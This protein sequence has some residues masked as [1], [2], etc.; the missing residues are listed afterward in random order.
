MT[1]PRTLSLPLITAGCLSTALYL[2]MS[3]VS[4]SYGAAGFAQAVVVYGGAGGLI[5]L[6]T[7]WLSRQL[8]LLDE[9]GDEQVYVSLALGLLGFGVLFRLLGVA[10][11]PVLEDDFYRYL[12]DGRLFVETGQPY[13]VAPS[14]YF[15]SDELSERFE[16]ILD[17]INYPGVAT[18]Y[19]PTLQLVF[20]LAYLIAP[21]EVW[22][23]QCLV[24]LADLVIL[25]ILFC[26]TGADT[27]GRLLGFGLYA[28]S[29]LLIKEFATTAH[30]D[31]L[32][33][34]LVFVA[35]SLWRRA[36]DLDRSSLWP[37]VLTGALLA[38]ASGVKP[39]ALIFAP[40]LIG[41]SVPRMLGFALGVVL[42]SLPFTGLDPSLVAAVWLPEGLR[43]MG[44]G[45]LFNAGLYE[46]FLWLGVE[47]LG[48]VRLGTLLAFAL[49]WLVVLLRFLFTGRATGKTAE[50]PHA[51]ARS[52]VWLFGVFLL[53]LPALN[54]WYLAWWLPFAVLCPWITPWVASFAVLLSYVSGINVPGG[55]GVYA[56]DAL[57]SLPGWVLAVEFLVIALAFA[58]DIRRLPRFRT[59]PAN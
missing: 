33:A 57:Y 10:S 16:T 46:L 9:Q 49:I 53:I 47:Q 28:W 31:I 7:L 44:Q 1:T 39:F 42:L 35:Y 37:G 50:Q 51:L 2:Y 41:F 11:F 14:D 52:F 43:A 45:W 8:N 54:P 24:A 4:H 30:P 40:F 56:Y 55:S 58:V 17:G 32:G 22:P 48:V 29:P 15:G 38:F 25:L 12:W 19:G 13:G 59:N 36:R 21:G 5:L 27:P 6:L 26:W 20:G 23:V 34:A 18:V 3:V